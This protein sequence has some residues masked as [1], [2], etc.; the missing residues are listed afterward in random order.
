MV[1]WHPVDRYMLA[2]WRVGFGAAGMPDALQRLTFVISESKELGSLAPNKCGYAKLLNKVIEYKPGVF[3]W[4][5]DVKHGRAVIELTGRARP[6]LP[7][8]F[9]CPSRHLKPS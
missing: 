8:P 4:H 9:S 7:F 5:T 2:V 1:F 6:A 3:Q